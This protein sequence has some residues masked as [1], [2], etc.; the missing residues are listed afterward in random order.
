MPVDFNKARPAPSGRAIAAPLDQETFLITISL[1]VAGGVEKVNLV[2]I[3][4]TSTDCVG[5]LS[6]TACTLESAIGEYDISIADNITTAVNLSKPRILAIANN[7]AVVPHQAGQ[8]YGRHKST[9]AGAVSLVSGRLG[10]FVTIFSSNGSVQA[11]S[12]GATVALQYIVRNETAGE[13]SLKTCE[14]FRDPQPDVIASL[15][16]AM[17]YFGA[18]TAKSS[19]DDLRQRLD[20]GLLD[21]V[22]TTV[23]GQVVGE[24]N[25]FYSNYWWF[26]AATIVEVVC[27]LTLVPTYWGWWRL[28]RGFSFSPLEIAQAF[29]SPLF[30]SYDS[31]ASGWSLA[32]A[33]PHL[34]VRYGVVGS[35]ANTHTVGDE[36]LA[37]AQEDL[38]R[39]P[40]QRSTY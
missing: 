34:R 10:S 2:T 12:L 7:T 31:N 24:H 40:Q 8:E 17:I 21:N 18:F 30:A 9:L 29:G 14:S 5:F 33:A 3:H 22:N 27:I 11:S 1:S 26:F 4:S 25:V 16:T 36:R 19:R 39:E 35:P 38:V 37:F 23:T 13:D 32:S 6:V 28:G 15:N 20:S